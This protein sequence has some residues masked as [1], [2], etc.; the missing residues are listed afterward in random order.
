MFAPAPADEPE[1]VPKPVAAA[2][3]LVSPRRA[4]NPWFVG[5]PLG[6]VFSRMR[7]TTAT[8]GTEP[9]TDSATPT[10]PTAPLTRPASWGSETRRTVAVLPFKNLARDPAVRI[11]FLDY[12]W[13]LNDVVRPR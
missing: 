2:P 6:R 4:R 13:S 1:H 10:R 5:G 9:R 3:A 11:A 12:N 8:A 7:T